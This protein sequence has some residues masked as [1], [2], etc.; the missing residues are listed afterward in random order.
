MATQ[1]DHVATPATPNPEPPFDKHFRSDEPNAT[2]P[3]RT[4]PRNLADSTAQNQDC[5]PLE[6]GA[7]DTETNETQNASIIPTEI[8]IGEPSSR[9]IVSCRILLITDSPGRVRQIEWALSTP[10]AG[11]FQLRIEPTLNS[12]RAPLL[13]T[14]FDLVMIDLVGAHGQGDAK[15]E[16][17]SR[18]RRI[19]SDLPILALS[20]APHTDAIFRGAQDCLSTE[21][22]DPEWLPRIVEHA[23]QRQLLMEQFRQTNAILDRKTS[24]LRRENQSLRKRN[25]RLERLQTT[26]QEFINHVSH[27]FRSPLT[28]VKEYASLLAEGLMGP[29]SER[30]KEFLEVIDTRTDELGQMLDDLLEISRLRSGTAIICR[31][32]CGAEDIFERVRVPLETRAASRGVA[33]TFRA[34]E[35]LP[36]VYCD[37]DKIGR[38]I[39]ALVQSSLKV[40]RQG[41]MIDVWVDEDPDADELCFGVTDTGPSLSEKDQEL[42]REQL[43]QT[44]EFVGAHA[45]KLGLTLN[46]VR[47]LLAVNLG[48]TN[49]EDTHDGRRTFSFQLPC[50]NEERL[51]AR[52]L[53]SLGRLD[54]DCSEISVLVVQPEP[55]S[56]IEFV[57]EL[58]R[59]LQLQMER[60]D[61][62]LRVD[63]HKWVAFVQC[64]ESEVDAVIKR[65]R[66]AWA[67][68]D[69]GIF[70]SRLPKIKI[71]H[72]GT[73]TIPH[74]SHQLLKQFQPRRFHTVRQAAEPCVLVVDDDWR[75]A[76]G[77][78]R[79]LDAAGYAS[80]TAGDAETALEM[81]AHLH[82]RAILL[83]NGL[84]GMNGIEALE[85]LQRNPETQDIPVI[86]ISANSK[87]QQAALAR[88]AKFCLPKPCEFDTILSALTNTLARGKAMSP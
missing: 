44:E 62:T 6:Q 69:T 80:E 63:A 75:F 14:P 12:A 23:L 71:E 51:A 15:A 32:T 24:E 30:Q 78:H 52:Y 73:W 8:R 41:D 59:V 2:V 9:R 48:T 3:G 53:A 64:A 21:Q 28:V 7:P 27:D 34:Q 4:A 42:V 13:E 70:Q 60:H 65:W 46:L 17:V 83:D 68:S 37:P 81:A 55:S 18:L 35:S 87:L 67:E 22:L 10:A 19:R 39:T 76:D 11:V 43:R 77:L 72:R 61:F 26:S 49:L 38:A 16:A 54:A 36:P 40:C 20:D 57:E 85:Q 1:Q 47:E 31:E 86:M 25:D 84:P 74:D 56:E 5:P 33:I 45:A 82:P 29:V 79:R 66:G 88:N 50:A 58:N